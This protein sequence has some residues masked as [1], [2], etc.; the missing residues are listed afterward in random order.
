MLSKLA[1]TSLRSFSI[2]QGVTGAPP[3]PILG[4]NEQ[5]GKEQRPHKVLLGMGAYR[6]DDDKPY[7]LSCVKK[8]TQLIEQKNMNHEY[9]PIT[10]NA[11]FVDKSIKLAYGEEN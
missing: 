1:G 4:L 2:W 11:S 9:S 6:D 5:Y 3:D 8:A 7:I 10:G